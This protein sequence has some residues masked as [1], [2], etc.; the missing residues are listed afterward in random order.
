MM[1]SFKNGHH[2]KIIM[3]ICESIIELNELNQSRITF[4]A[5]C[6]HHGEK[7]N[8]WKI[9]LINNPESLY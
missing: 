9:F 2:L 8:A 7:F 3:C 1:F 4:G 5:T 6:L